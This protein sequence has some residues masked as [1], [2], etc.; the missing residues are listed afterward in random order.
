[1]NTRD[2]TRKTALVTGAASGIGR[3]TALELAR[4]GADLFL[5]DLDKDGVQRTA[6]TARELGRRARAERVDVASAEEMRGLA[7]AVHAEVPAVDLLIN[8]AGVG[9]GAG[10]LDTSLEDWEWILGVNVR[11]VVHGCHFF[12]PPMI[13]AG[14][15]GH[16]INLASA[17]AFLPIEALCAYTLTKYAVLGLS[18][19]LESEL[20]PHRIGVTA[21]CPGAID[22]AIVRT[23]R[24]RG[25]YDHE[26]AREFAVRSFARSG[27]APERAARSI[28]RAVQR[29]R[30]VA[31]ITP[32]AWIAYYAKR[33]APAPTRALLR[34]GQARALRELERARA[35]AR[36]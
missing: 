7:A 14:R 32:A 35:G 16:V 26:R 12:L 25:R 24:L 4:R 6:E 20:R 21:A 23:A 15:G 8:N 30:V 27:L 18:E 3:A 34:A 17:A 33:L 22:T 28:L 1:M 10:F 29:G 31:P 13:A 11:G 36:A 2:L 9:L 19:A 5:C